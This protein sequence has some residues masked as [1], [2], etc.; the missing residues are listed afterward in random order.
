MRLVIHLAP[1]VKPIIAAK[2]SRPVRGW[3][4]FRVAIIKKQGIAMLNW[5]AG[6]GALTVG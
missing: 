5:H 2:P 3:Q 4:N 1:A 6:K